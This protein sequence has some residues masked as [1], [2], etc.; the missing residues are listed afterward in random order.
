MKDSVFVQ[1]ATKI[2]KDYKTLYVTGGF[3]APALPRN[4][5]RYTNNYPQNAKEPRR[6]NILNA[7]ADTFFFDCTGLIKGILWGWDGNRNAVYG[8][9]QYGSNGV[10]DLEPNGMIAKCK[11]VSTNF[12][13]IQ[14]GEMLWLTGHAGIYIGDGLAVECTPAWKNDVQITAVGNIGAKTGYPTRVWSKH[15]KLPW[16]EYTGVKPEPVDENPYSVL[17]VL[18]VG[19]NGDLVTLLQIQL[20][21]TA[22]GDFGSQTEKA[23]KA[24][25]K[26]KKL[27]VDGVVGKNTYKALFG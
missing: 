27:E 2:A 6:S 18:R 26:T 17:P 7:S 14:P 21:I 13:N 16:V 15:G 11:D 23:V 25:Q 5:T 4:K 22:D 12:A 24:Y 3:G 9:A 1:K 19:S 8:G 10:P 20:K